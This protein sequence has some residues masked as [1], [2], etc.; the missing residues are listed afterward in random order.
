MWLKCGH[1]SLKA[2]VRDDSARGKYALVENA[3]INSNRWRRGD[4]LQCFLEFSRLLHF[5]RK[6]QILKN[7]KGDR[8]SYPAITAK[9][10]QTAGEMN[11]DSTNF[12]I[13]ALDVVNSR[14]FSV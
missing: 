9:T 5:L 7:E 4:K 11:I 12:R 10:L 3:N 1:I 13:F 2:K 14:T 8:V 6:K